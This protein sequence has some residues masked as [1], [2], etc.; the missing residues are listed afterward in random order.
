MRP[1][2]VLLAAIMISTAGTGLA[3]ERL[4]SSPAY[5]APIR[6]PREIAN[7]QFAARME[8]LRQEA[9]RQQ[10]AD[11]GTLTPEHRAQLQAKLDRLHETHRRLVARNDALSVNADGS[12]RD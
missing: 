9:V 1:R 11:G 2:S 5:V 4:L 6:T 8:A 12:R 10:Q 7:R 3:Q